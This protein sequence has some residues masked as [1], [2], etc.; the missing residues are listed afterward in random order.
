MKRSLLEEIS[1]FLL[2]KSYTIKNLTSSCLDILARN[3]KNII[4]I[5]VLE[6]ANSI[7][8]EY[9][10]EM[11]RIS[12]YIKGTPLIIAN[13]AGTTLENNIV[14]KR[15]GI[16]TLNYNTFVNSLNNKFPFVKRSQAGL[17]ACLNGKRLRKL[18][19]EE[20]YS[21][22]SLSKKI[23]VTTKM[24]IKYENENSEV[25][26]SRASKLYD[27]FGESVFNKIDI[28]SKVG[29]IEEEKTSPFSRQ[30]I[31]LG[32]EASDTNKAPFDII[33]KKEEEIILTDIGDKIDPNLES[34]TRLLDAD[35]LV[36]FKKKKPKKIPAITKKE[37]MEFDKADELIKFV[38]EF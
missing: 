33:A 34:L 36:I 18:R 6:D 20:G 23:G 5:K 37:F 14:Y 35:N 31:K 28:L 26:L 12:S 1:I 19:E 27:L 21:L 30:Y 15:F 17:T 2:R 25:T 38:K 7:S 22:N 16:F 3:N 4:L 11:I 24:V 32:F 8:K 13:K 29:K 9:C 10:E